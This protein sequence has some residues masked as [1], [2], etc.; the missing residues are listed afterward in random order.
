MYPNFETFRKKYIP[1]SKGGN[2]KLMIKIM[3]FLI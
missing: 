1:N 2:F 3:Y